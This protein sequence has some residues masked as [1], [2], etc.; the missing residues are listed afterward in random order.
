MH[1]PRLLHQTSL[2]GL[3][4]PQAS[5]AAGWQAKGR[6]RQRSSSQERGRSGQGSGRLKVEVIRLDV[7]RLKDDNDDILTKLLEQLCH[8]SSPKI[9]SYHCLLSVCSYKSTLTQT[10]FGPG[11]SGAPLGYTTTSL[12]CLLSYGETPSY[13]NKRVVRSF[14]LPYVALL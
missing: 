4:A 10:L 14:N 12:F 7:Y 1:Q 9:Q 2:Q 13:P 5:S 8:F 3:P 6:K 11:C